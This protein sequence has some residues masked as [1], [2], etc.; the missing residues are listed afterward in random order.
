[1]YV[2][3]NDCAIAQDSVLRNGRTLFFYHM[4]VLLVFAWADGVG[5]CDT[6][7]TLEKERKLRNL[8]GYCK[9]SRQ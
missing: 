5:Y 3:A 8:I 2:H 6:N 9:V 1:M 4:Y 7:L